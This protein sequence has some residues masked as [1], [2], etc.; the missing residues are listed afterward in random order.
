MNVGLGVK[1]R[2]L[3]APRIA[4]ALHYTCDPYPDDVLH[5]CNNP[6]CVNPHHLRLGDDMR[7]KHDS[8]KAGTYCHGSTVNTAKLTE[9]DVVKIKLAIAQGVRNCEL[10]IRFHVC[11]MVISCI[12]RGKTWRH[13]KVPGFKPSIMKG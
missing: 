12:R 6:N 8:I 2:C 10:A 5:D 13:V 4:Y 7:N 3:L 1:R 9:G 11:N